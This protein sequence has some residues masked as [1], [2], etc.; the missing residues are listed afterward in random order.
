MTEKEK[1]LAGMLYHDDDD[2]LKT[3]RCRCEL[4]CQEY[5]MHDP[6][7]RVGQREIL[8]KI[9]G[10]AKT[11]CHITP[12]FHCDYGYN[13]SLG[14]KFYSNYNLVILDCAKVTIGNNVLIAP[15]V[16]IYTVGHPVVVE[17]R[18]TH[19]EYAY[20]VTIG[21][22]VWIG[23]G[24]SILPGVTI[25]SGSVIGAG[26]VVTHD[27]PPNVVACGNPCRVLREI[28]ED[29]IMPENEGQL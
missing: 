13:I 18:N 21:D 5:N 27:I 17:Q 23:G 3:E 2:E 22:N 29:D 1:M 12:P 24:V 15:N 26:S 8:D 7:D 28:T 11:Y 4:L 20:P 10:S 19:L 14:D 9:L 6:T 16:G 25:G